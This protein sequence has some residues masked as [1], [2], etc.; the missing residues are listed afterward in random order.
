M[1]CIQILRR[2]MKQ[3][4]KRFSTAFFLFTLFFVFLLF[5]PNIF[6]TSHLPKGLLVAQEWEQ[7][8]A[9]EFLLNVSL[10][11]AFIAGIVTILSPCLLPLLPA[12]FSYTFKEKTK[13]TF[14]TLIF[15]AG[16]TSMFIAMGLVAAFFGIASLLILQENYSF[17]IQIAGAIL[18]L[19]GFMALAG[20]GF[21]GILI[22]KK[23]AH[24][25]FGVFLYGVLFALGWT[26]CIGPILAGV[27]SMAA[28]F[29][30]Y[31]T[32]VLLMFFYSLGMFVPVFLFSYFYDTHH[33]EKLP[34]IQGKMY[35]FSFRNKAY[36][37]HTS[38]LISGVLF[39]AVGIFFIIF[40][41]TGPISSLYYFGLKDLFY[42]IQRMLLSGGIVFN[43]LGVLIISIVVYLVYKGL[44]SAKMKNAKEGDIHGAHK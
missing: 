3:Q 26:V 40:K 19:F 9:K 34:W 41:G 15:F 42:D 27:L 44:R 38:N 33:W 2:T 36:S 10:L 16:F 30:N 4:S 18:I 17:F 1:Q 7:E 35:S 11:V 39:L 23:T 21:S 13:I 31:F 43:I 12:F 14:M 22:R 32:A 29:H 37:I 8:S 6:A 24:D 25:S 20:T 5:V 28:L